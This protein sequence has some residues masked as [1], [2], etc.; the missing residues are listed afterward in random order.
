[1]ALAMGLWLVAGFCGCSDEEAD[2]VRFATLYDVVEYASKNDGVTNFS[3]YLP[4]SEE[5]VRL[6]TSSPVNLGEIKEGEALLLAYT[7]RAG[8][9]YVSDE[10]DVKGLGA[11]TNTKLMK[12]KPETLVGWDKDPVWVTSLWRAGRNVLM[13]IQLVYDHIPRVFRLVVDESTMGSEYPEAYLVNI[14]RGDDGDNYMKQYYVAFDLHAFWTHPEYK[15][16]K[17]HVNNSNN[18]SLKEFLIERPASLVVGDVENIPD[19]NNEGNK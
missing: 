2:G 11:V 15:G 4:D 8:K 16:L 3:L 1:M 13:R 7:P 12:G 5:A 19:G 17:I 10:V 6:Y 9:A 18:T 14:R